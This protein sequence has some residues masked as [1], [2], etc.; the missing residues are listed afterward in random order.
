[1]PNFPGRREGVVSRLSSR[2]SPLRPLYGTR[3]GALHVDALPLQYDHDRW[4]R[5][6]LASWPADSAAH[7]SYYRR[8]LNGPAQPPI[9]TGTRHE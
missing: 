2:A 9:P 5:Q 1:M 8:I 4:V 6:F 7:K 3:I